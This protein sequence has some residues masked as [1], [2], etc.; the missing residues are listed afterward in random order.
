MQNSKLR[1]KIQNLFSKSKA[2]SFSLFAFPLQKGQSLIE[3]IIVMGLCAIIL[4]ALL[5]GLMSSREGKAQQQQRMQAVY[6]LNETVDAIRSVRERSWEAFAINGT[7]H[8][9]T[10]SGTWILSPGSTTID[11]FTQQITIGDINRDSSGMIV[12]SGGALDPS[13]KK[14]D[15]SISWDKPYPSAITA[16]LYMTRYL[17]NNSYTQTTVAD[18]SAG[19][20]SNTAIPSPPYDN[21]EVILGVGGGGGD[22]CQPAA[23]IVQVDLPKSGTANAISAIEGTVFTGTGENSSGI[24]FA[25]IPLVGD[26]P[27]SASVAATFDGYKTN[28]AVF[29]DETYAYL[30]TDNN[31][32]EV[33]IINLTQFTDPPINSKYKE[34]GYIDVAGNVDGDGV[35]VSNNIAYVLAGNKLYIYDITVREGIH[36]IEL[37]TGGLTLSGTGKRILV[38]PSSDGK[39]YAYVATNSTSNQFQVIN[40]SNSASPVVVS[41]K[42]IGNSQSG[43]D[44]FVST[45]N[46]AVDR[47]YFATS[48]SSGGPDFFILDIST[49]TNPVIIGNG[50]NTQG[51]SPKGLTVVTGNR[52]I[53]VGSGGTNQYQ[54]LK[55][56]DE[57]NPE[58]CGGL[59]YSTG[60]NGVASVLQGNGYAYSYIITGDSNA[61]LKII[62][63]GA[64]EE[65]G[66]Y[67]E[68]GSFTSHPF[69]AGYTTAFNR[70]D[71]VFAQPSQTTIKFQVA[72][73][74]DIGGSCDG[75][76]Y[77]FIGPDGTDQTFFTSSTASI[78]LLSSGD[79]RNPGRCF[80]YKAFLTTNDSTQTPELDSFMINYSP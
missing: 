53:I 5:T 7:Y 65:G 42:T 73:A 68:A 38:A 14:V 31:S 51:M 12:E 75:A 47:A 36:S 27:S 24:S 37:N 79:Y 72:I 48:Y 1:I 59:E 52:A 57:L 22:W 56:S 49:K 58:Y 4:P 61:E 74:E 40:V 80:E 23:S 34:V 69:D 28:A 3:A 25:K 77:S 9:A 67:S 15:I 19:S 20:L 2:S 39:T 71:T 64:G 33:V 13:S 66:E 78:P 16:N 60:I 45:T 62:L 46:P 63:G 10:F 35:Y 17:E 55:I 30:G 70:F 8:T 21:G 41:Q 44:V 32:K 26:P 11:G 43:V 54:V 29:G 6:V 50:Y 76:N 18:F